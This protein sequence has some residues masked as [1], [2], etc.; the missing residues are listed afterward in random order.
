[1]PPFGALPVGM[2][3]VSS[4]FVGLS[5]SCSECQA[6]APPLSEQQEQQQATAAA[7]AVEQPAGWPQRYDNLEEEEP[8]LGRCSLTAAVPAASTGASA[9][10]A[11]PAASTAAAEQQEGGRVALS[12][13]EGRAGDGA[14]ASSIGEGGDGSCADTRSWAYQLGA[15]ALGAPGAGPMAADVAAHASEAGAAS[16]G[17]VGP[18]AMQQQAEV[19]LLGAAGPAAAVRVAQQAAASPLL[20]L[21]AADSSSMQ[22]RQQNSSVAAA[23]VAVQP[24]DA[25]SPAKAAPPP[26]PPKPAGRAAPSPPPPPPG[27]KAV[28]GEEAEAAAAAGQA[29]SGR[30]PSKP[31]VK[32]FW[33][34]LPPS[35]VRA[36]VGLHATKR[37][38]SCA[39]ARL[40]LH[41]SLKLCAHEVCP[42][43][44]WVC[45]GALGQLLRGNS[46][47]ALTCTLWHR[48]SRARCGSS[49]RGWML[50][51]I[52]TCW[53]Q[54][55]LPRKQP[56]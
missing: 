24:G 34:K 28:Q 9:A 33:N 3:R 41:V 52:M 13:N 15:S 35:Q 18:A 31:M 27:R 32:L 20:A 22:P 53:S 47:P 14:A 49:W 48:R 2:H 8:S 29:P 36:A 43:W 44:S 6:A 25:F 1:M 39:D 56:G 38:C 42:A 11:A 21:A 37:R 55:L 26:P 7:W 5:G 46:S 51:W 17:P 50:R 10:P 12:S 19:C 30:T 23:A 4:L 54:S 16:G 40:H 45:S